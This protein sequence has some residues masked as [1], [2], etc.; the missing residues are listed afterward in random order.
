MGLLY[1]SLCFKKGFE[2]TVSFSDVLQEQ[3]L[4]KAELAWSGEG[5]V[6]R[7]RTTHTHTAVSRCS[8]HYN[9]IIQ[10]EFLR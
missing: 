10:L 7:L 1:R 9:L 8:A 4:L 6:L 5:V 3:C 2:M